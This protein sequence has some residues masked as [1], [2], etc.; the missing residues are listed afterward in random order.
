MNTSDEEIK[1][2]DQFYKF[3]LK[4]IVEDFNN[5]FQFNNMNKN[6]NSIEID[7]SDYYSDNIKFAKNFNL[8]AKN[9]NIQQILSKISR[10][11]DELKTSS[12]MSIQRMKVFDNEHFE[13][14]LIQKMKIFDSEHFEQTSSALFILKN[15]NNAN[16]Y[17]ISHS[18]KKLCKLTTFAVKF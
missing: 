9:I 13:K 12:E 10:D 16:F 4:S 15:D 18:L 5:I 7:F 1:F 14:M 17:I 6:H 11:T 3:F 2:V 8:N